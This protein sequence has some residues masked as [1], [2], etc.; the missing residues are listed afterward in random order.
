M[1]SNNNEEQQEPTYFNSLEP[2]DDCRVLGSL[3]RIT[4]A[5]AIV[6][7]CVASYYFGYQQGV[8]SVEVDSDSRLEIQE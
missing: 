5:S 1:N 3:E 7:V 2:L 4:L 6:G 8:D